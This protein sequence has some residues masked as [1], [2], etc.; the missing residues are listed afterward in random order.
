ML[1]LVVTGLGVAIFQ[2][3]SI[4][5]QL[6]GLS[7]GGAPREDLVKWLCRVGAVTLF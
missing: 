3:F 4:E 7:T 6:L 2:V 5:K 1:E